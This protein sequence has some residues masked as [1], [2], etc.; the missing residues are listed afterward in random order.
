M[1]Q[2]ETKMDRNRIEIGGLET[3]MCG[4]GHPS[5]NGGM[6]F[7]AD[8]RLLIPAGLQKNSFLPNM[9]KNSCVYVRLHNKTSKIKLFQPGLSQF[10]AI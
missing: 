2:Y 9:L 3:K 6:R 1:K 7:G 5:F 4:R 8:L 10:K